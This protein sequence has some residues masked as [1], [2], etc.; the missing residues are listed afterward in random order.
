MQLFKEDLVE[1]KD[2]YLNSEI[3][4]ID[5]ASVKFLYS[6]VLIIMVNRMLKLL[7]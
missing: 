7:I 4:C 5:K 3:A 1:N 2:F 6:N